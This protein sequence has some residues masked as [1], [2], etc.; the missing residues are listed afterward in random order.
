MKVALFFLLVGI[1]A[2][3]ARGSYPGEISRTCD[4]STESKCYSHN[5]CVL[6]CLVVVEQ[7]N[8]VTRMMDLHEY[9]ATDYHLPR[10]D[11]C[12]SDFCEAVERELNQPITG[13]GFCELGMSS[14]RLQ[15]KHICICEA[16]GGRYGIGY[17]TYKDM[18]LSEMFD[19][20]PC[21]P[22]PREEREL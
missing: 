12:E 7:K 3:C 10:G 11:L 9:C 8:P 1:L 13:N 20:S 17:Q 6:G 15:T 14:D 19:Q 21:L 4:S 22:D 5:P 18:D 2:S 16:G